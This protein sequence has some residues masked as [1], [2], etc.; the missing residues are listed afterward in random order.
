VPW[1]TVTQ[2]REVDRLMIED[3]RIL[4]VRM[5]ENAGRNLAS[6]ARRMLEGNAAGARVLVLGGRGGNGAGRLVAARHLASAGAQVEVRLSAPPEELAPA[7]AAECAILGRIGVRVGVGPV[8]WTLEPDLV[9]DALLG[10]GQQGEPRRT[11]AELIESVAGRRTLS[12]DGPSGLELSTGV[13]QEPFVRA[14]A[15]LTVALPKHGLRAPGASASVGKLYL[16]DI[17]V[18]SVVY[19][20]VGIA[21][22][23]PFGASTIVQLRDR[24]EG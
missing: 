11:T 24:G 10:Y 2:M 14:L 5:L 13:L 21:Y 17:S 22:R 18:P 23:S 8:R 7:A 16:A 20:R 3:V 15:T 9:I 6:L 19:H 12:L 4:L 1:L